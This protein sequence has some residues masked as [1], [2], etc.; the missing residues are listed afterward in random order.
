V[1]EE[2]IEVVANTTVHRDV[3]V[4]ATSLNG[5]VTADDGTDVRQLN[6][7]IA[8]LAGLTEL[9][10]DYRPSRQQGGRG[11]I[12]TRLQGGRY[13]FDAVTPGKYLIVVTIPGRQLTTAPVVIGTSGSQE[14]TIPAGSLDS[15]RRR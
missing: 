10:A 15:G 3:R 6:G 11:S 7:D 2:A 1:H 12:R 8:L 5:A 14:V 9:P 13:V 4:Y